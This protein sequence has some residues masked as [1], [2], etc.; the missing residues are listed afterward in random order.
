MSV[1]IKGM[2]MPIDGNETIIRIR[3]DGTVLDQYGHHLVI[4][5]VP[6][7]PHGRLIDADVLRDLCDAPHWCVWL[8]EIDDAQTIIP[9]EE[10]EL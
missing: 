10:C 7:P 3:S 2:E 6:V 5:A 9:A 4:T 8:S 1:L